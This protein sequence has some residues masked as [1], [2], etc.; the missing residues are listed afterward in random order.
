[1]SAAGIKQPALSAR[2]EE[3]TMR[4]FYKQLS[5]RWGKKL[6]LVCD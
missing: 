3:E 2:A 6:P 1:M 5:G 4:A